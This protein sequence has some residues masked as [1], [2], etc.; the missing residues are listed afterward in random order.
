[1]NSGIAIFLHWR[2]ANGNP[3][4]NFAP[5]I[6]AINV[7]RYTPAIGGPNKQQQHGKWQDNDAM[8]KRRSLLHSCL[9][10]V[11]Q[12]LQQHEASAFVSVPAICRFQRGRRLGAI[13][14]SA[15]RDVEGRRSHIASV[16]SARLGGLVSEGADPDVV[17]NFGPNPLCAVT[18][19]SGSG[20][21]LLVSKGDF[22]VQH[23]ELDIKNRRLIV[24]SSGEAIDLVTG[25]KAASSLIPT[26]DRGDDGPETPA[27]AEMSEYPTL[28]LCDDRHTK[29][30]RILNKEDIRQANVSVVTNPPH[31]ISLA[32]CVHLVSRNYFHESGRAP[33]DGHR[34]DRCLAVILICWSAIHVI[35]FLLLLVRSFDSIR[36]PTQLRVQLLANV[37]PRSSDAPR[38]SRRWETPPALAHVQ[39]WRLRPPDINVPDQRRG[40]FAQGAATGRGAFDHAR[41]RQ[42][43]GRGAGAASVEVGHPRHGRGS[44]RQTKLCA[45]GEVLP[46]GQDAP[47]G[48]GSRRAV[49][50]VAAFVPRAWQRRQPRRRTN[51]IARALGRGTR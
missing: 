4:C 20:K 15:A 2:V 6:I 12:A 32:R 14:A 45:V 28:P 23:A 50:H 38:W 35:F 27:L 7:F 48:R 41:R 30:P 5:I 18:G 33:S 16:R 19:E 26:T 46:G 8:K 25:G 11:A 9:I 37:R 10:H 29:G 47:G 24:S 39:R 22:A 44:S 51:G 1:M 36:T 31:D 34:R 13:A 17:V 21:S 3:N 43:G 49:S 40:R 42:R